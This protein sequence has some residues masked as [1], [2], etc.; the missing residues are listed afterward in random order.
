VGELKIKTGFDTIEYIKE[1]QDTP[2]AG[3]P[4]EQTVMADHFT[5]SLSNEDVSRSINVI[6]MTVDEALPIV[7]RAIDHALMRGL[8]TIEI[9]H[10]LGTGRLK[11]A[12]R[13]HLKKESYVKC[14]ASDD[15]TRG[16]AGI[17][18]V[19]IHY[20]PRNTSRK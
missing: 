4:Q 12:I 19:E 6:G 1:T 16:G 13:A 15:Q 2:V 11:E 9:I 8:D 20:N 7:D 18:R 14:C 10:G 3:S 5:M 17:T